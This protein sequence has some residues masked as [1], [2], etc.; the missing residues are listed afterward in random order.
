MIKITS[1]LNIMLLFIFSTSLIAKSACFLATEDNNIII[2]EGAC[3]LRHEPRCS[4]NIALSLMGFNEELLINENIPEFPFKKGY[5]DYVS[6][7]RQPHN[8]SLW[9]K[10]SC[11]WY[12]SLVTQKLGMDKLQH[13]IKKFTYGNQDG[14]V[15]NNK[16]NCFWM[17][18]GS[19]KISPEEQVTFL[20]KLINHQLNVSTKSYEMTKNIIF[21]DN[22]I[23]G[24]KLY[25]KTGTGNLSNKNGTLDENLEGGWFVGWI[26]KDERKIVFAS[27]LE[28]D[29]QQI[30]AGHKAKEIATQRLSAILKTNSKFIDKP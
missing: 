20:Q 17:S 28:Q 30:P 11:V 21:V 23:D 14:R 19:L 13:Y 15:A 4:F 25:G 2:S 26:E 8:P 1:L 7:W 24:W 12:S 22:F 10:N 18:G 27:Y 29:T 9:I 5:V 3:K 16:L 6:R